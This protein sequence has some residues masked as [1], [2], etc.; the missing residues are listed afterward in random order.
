MELVVCPHCNFSKQVSIEKLKENQN[1]KCRKCNKVFESIRKSSGNAVVKKSYKLPAYYAPLTKFGVILFLFFAFL[2]F[3]IPLWFVYPVGIIVILAICGIINIFLSIYCLTWVFNYTKVNIEI[4]VDG[5]WYSHLQK[6]E[7]LVPWTQIQSVKEHV[8]RNIDLLDKRGRILIKVNEGLTK[9]LALLH[10]I[11]DRSPHLYTGISLPI[12]LQTL[13][14]SIEI[15]KDEF[16]LKSAF[17]TYKYRFEDI[18]HV[19]LWQEHKPHLYGGEHRVLRVSLF[20]KN[21]TETIKIPR[22]HN[23]E[24]IYLYKLFKCL[25]KV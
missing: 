7:G 18:D 25:A 14:Q 4:D 22:F 12:K 9:D 2:C 17:N 23:V 11:I 19:E 5:I 8:G 13:T 20:A 15:D 6:Q 24:V 10:E 21:T 1:L 3:A 16:I